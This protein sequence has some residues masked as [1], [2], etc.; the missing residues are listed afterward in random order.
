[1]RG[2]TPPIVST[3]IHGYFQ[4]PYYWTKA[5]YAPGQP[6]NLLGVKYSFSEVVKWRKPGNF[7][8]G[9]ASRMVEIVNGHRGFT[10]ARRVKITGL[11]YHMCLYSGG[12][13]GGGEGGRGGGGEC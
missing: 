3:G 4:D 11:T 10:T 9:V 6:R 5:S 2:N 13:G 1:M 8:M 7:L 12:G